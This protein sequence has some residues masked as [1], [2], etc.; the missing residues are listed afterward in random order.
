MNHCSSQSRC[1][2]SN[3]EHSHSLCWSIQKNLI[4]TQHIALSLIHK[5][6]LLCYQSFYAEAFLSPATFVRGSAKSFTSSWSFPIL[7]IELTRTFES[8]LNI[9]IRPCFPLSPTLVN[10]LSISLFCKLPTTS[11]NFHV[12]TN[13]LAMM[14]YIRSLLQIL[15]WSFVY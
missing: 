15:S 6:F 8:I 9:S 5:V 1:L 4:P 10:S 3:D 12:C 7:L 13:V 2:I 14:S 11:Y